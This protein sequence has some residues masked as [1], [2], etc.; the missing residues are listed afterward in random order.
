[1]TTPTYI[2]ILLYVHSGSS[3]AKK[4]LQKLKLNPT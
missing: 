3:A 2:T 4:N 1:M